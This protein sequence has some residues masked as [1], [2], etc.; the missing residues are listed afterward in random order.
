LS[1]QT[2]GRQFGASAGFAAAC[3][4]DV[5]LFQLTLV[6]SAITRHG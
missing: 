4:A 2:G 1:H 3:F 5:G 6:T